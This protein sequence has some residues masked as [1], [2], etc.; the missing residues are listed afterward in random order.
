MVATSLV[1]AKGQIAIPLVI[2]KK[3][4]IAP[5]DKVFYSVE[6][7]RFFVKKLKSVDIEWLNAV[8]STLDEWNNP[9]DDDL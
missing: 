2:R 5:G 9:D 1:S 7:D 6:G 3:L 8:G 4:N